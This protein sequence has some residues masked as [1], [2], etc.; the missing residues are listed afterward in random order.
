MDYLRDHGDAA[1]SGALGCFVHDFCSFLLQGG[2]H[3]TLHSATADLA[4]VYDIEDVD[5]CL[6]FGGYLEGIV[7]GRICWLAPICGK[8]DVVVH[9][10][11]LR[12]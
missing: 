1:F 8:E 2:T 11:C 9:M 10:I 4:G 6:V 5:R 12:E 3:I 7:E